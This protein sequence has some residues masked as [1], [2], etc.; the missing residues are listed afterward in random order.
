MTTPDHLPTAISDAI[1]AFERRRRLVL[2]LRGIGEA[3]VIQVGALTVVA[4]VDQFANPALGTRVALSLSAWCV[5]GSVLVWRGLVPALARR[6]ALVSAHALERAAGG[7]LAERLTSAIE[8]TATP[9]AGV[10]VWMINRTVALAAQAAATLDPVRLVSS[11]PARRALAAGAL[12]VTALGLACLSP[13]L[14]ALVSRA[15]W[16]HAGVGRPSGYAISV[17]PG[18]AVIAQGARFALAA[19]ITPGP[20]SA[21]VVLRWDDGLEQELA[22]GGDVAGSTFRLDLSAVT[23][24]FA[25]QVRAG[26]GESRIF[27][28]AVRP[29]PALAGLSVQ[30]RPPTYTG[31]PARSQEGGDVDVVAGSVIAVQAAFSGE[32][33]AAAALMREGREDQALL[34]AADGS[35]GGTEFTPEATQSYGLRLVGR[36]GVRAEPPQRW[37]VTVRPDAA[38]SAALT[39]SGVS[40][41]LAGADEVLL[42]A[43][44]ADDDLG[45]R[46]LD[47][48]IADDRGELER[49]PLIPQSP[50]GGPRAF[51]QSTAVD[52][53]AYA[54]VIGDRL[55]LTLEAEDLGGQRAGSAP[56]VVTVTGDDEALAAAWAEALR[57][58][59]AALDAQAAVLRQAEKSWSAL[60][61]AHRPEDPAAQRGDALLVAARCDE[62]TAACAAIAARVLAQAAASAQPQAP[63]VE[64][65][66]A[67]LARWADVQRR[68]LADA[69]A[70]TRVG[71]QGSEALVR[72]RDL[73]ENALAGLGDLRQRFGL[74]VAR[75]RAEGL[76]GTGDAAQ[77]RTTRAVPVLRGL[78]AWRGAGWR[79]GLAG[80]VFAGI[81]LAGLPLREVVGL[82]D[83]AIAP[84][85]RREDWSARWLGEFRV[86]VDGDYE[87]V[88]TVDDGVRLRIDGE[89]LLPAA[90]WTTQPPTAHR[91][92]R[93]L[94]AG[95]H[96]MELEFFQG[97]GGMHLA[98]TWGAVDG[99]QVA[100]GLAHTRTRSVGE[101]P[102]QTFARAMA[103][104]SPTTGARALARLMQACSALATAPAA[105]RRMGEDAGLDTLQRLAE[106]SEPDG[107]R[108]A[109]V[110][111]GAEL[112]IAGDLVDLELRVSALAAAARQARDELERAAADVP[113]DRQGPLVDERSL[114][115]DIAQRGDALRHLDGNLSASDLAAANRREGAAAKATLAVL[116]ERLAQRRAE[117]I[118]RAASDGAT[119]AERAHALAAR[120]KLSGEVS[121]AEQALDDV[122]ERPANEPRQQGERVRQASDR[123]DQALERS[124]QAIAQADAARQAQR[125]DRARGE[126]AAVTAAERASDAP[127]A[128][129][130]RARLAR[131]LDEAAA[132]ERAAGDRSAADRIAAAATSDLATL[133]Q[134]L[135]VIERPHAAPALDAQASR[136]LAAV[137]KDLDDGKAPTAADEVRLAALELAVEGERRREE[138]QIELGTA[139]ARL[140]DQTVAAAH[141]PEAARVGAL[142]R[143]VE[144]VRAGDGPARARALATT[145]EA[146]P[147][148]DAERLDRL[149]LAAERAARDPA[150][151]NR[152]AADLDE[153]AVGADP[154]PLMP[155]ADALTR[156]HQAAALD[157][158]VAR[159]RALAAEETAARA[160]H[161]VRARA[162]AEL[163]ETTAREASATPVTGTGPAAEHLR[164]V[165][166]TLAERLPV[167]AQ[168]ARARAGQADQPA[169]ATPTP[170][171]AR[172]AAM[173][174]A[175]VEND[176]AAP[177]AEAWRAAAVADPAAPELVPTA[178]LGARLADLAAAERESGE[179][180][181][182]VLARREANRAALARGLADAAKADPAVAATM[183]ADPVTG[184]AADSVP[185][186]PIAGADAA[187]ARAAQAQADSAQA[188]ASLA[189]AKAEAE[190]SEAGRSAADPSQAAQRQEAALQ[191]HAA[192]I[193]RQDEALAAQRTALAEPA[194]AADP[195]LA[196]RAATNLATAAR[197]ARSLAALPAAVSS[198]TVS[199]AAALPA[200]QAASAHVALAQAT[201]GAAAAAD[202]AAAAL[203]AEPA[204][205][206]GPIASPVVPAASGAGTPASATSQG[207]AA[208]L[209]AL[210]TQAK[211][212][213]AW[214]AAADGLAAAAAQSRL[215]ALA[216]AAG[217][218]PT[219][220]AAESPPSA[221]E[222]SADGPPPTTAGA[223]NPG[224]ASSARPGGEGQ[225]SGE[226]AEG[227]ATATTGSDAAEWGRSRG[228]LRGDVM[229][230]GIETFGAEQ[231]E[232]IRAYFRR[233]GEER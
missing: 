214:S 56:L 5:G 31:L 165:V 93:R 187:A 69:S 212:D 176:F 106:R 146:A 30:V 227:D 160:E 28:V 13:T 195:D 61:R 52:L 156:E 33:V 173:S 22:L 20:G 229:A 112:L 23:Q 147:A 55:Q 34:V 132:A 192:A 47:L 172:A 161:A 103:T 162:S 181:D 84:S 100:L 215:S 168:A 7:V 178:A 191:A 133:D 98:V 4:L 151:R 136:R 99:A 41:G 213:A 87:F 60:A 8:L 198:S 185:L 184:P 177:L 70:A 66:A 118:A 117:L 183:T 2:L 37:L 233:L 40:A 94:G 58:E 81:A 101:V 51:T 190:A 167:Q 65:A 124:G 105:I 201:A 216:A 57:P 148:T 150:Q 120:E 228:D 19:E 199:P 78:M 43:A 220:A 225:R 45:L 12:A 121:V 62:A 25:Y 196:A 68:I 104:A 110:A 26:D 171:L 129:A 224:Q 29:P 89:E 48:V 180:L 166:A 163:A 207:A 210:R 49:R 24:G 79:P 203:R 32:M 46:R 197:T 95:W 123:L 194:L 88:C 142:A 134:A 80:K 17:Q 1:A 175:A 154:A 159:E 205:A 137:A 72:C 219:T 119:V 6:D 152:L 189:V 53:G 90:A 59:L 139:F 113:Q 73:S 231:Q 76:V 232:A 14:A 3:A 145:P 107:A 179:R 44:K 42:L 188:A 108:C 155:R 138:K 143:E 169:P 71:G 75:L 74:Q 206:N 170:Q 158:L 35:A 15:A 50:A 126:A 21:L 77:A 18:D 218:A 182:R 186:T 96:R 82:P 111:A 193:Q 16:P 122:L 174:A 10:S 221:G 116:S 54:L 102:D 164:A 217:L 204:A 91:G 39:A 128:T 157:R 149:A 131:T 135:S 85:N 27:H 202:R 200:D 86:D 153:A 92:R 141:T 114:A 130:A 230:S 226:S 144:A 211:P 209:A 97:S 64:A 63:R 83:V 140:A 222:A 38:P 223:S 208:A 36:S 67:A 127:A 9:A 109:A 115:R 125:A 11:R